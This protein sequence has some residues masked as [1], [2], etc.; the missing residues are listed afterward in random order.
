MF[1]IVLLAGSI[2]FYFWL[3]SFQ[4]SQV[5]FE[6]SGPSQLASGEPAAFTISYW[7]NTDQ[8]L[9]NAVLTVRYP[10]NVVSTGAVLER[11]DLGS[12]GVGSGGKQEINV[13]FFGADKS[14]VRLEAVLNY[15]PA[16]TS[17]TF[18]N[19]ARKDAGL[20]GSVLS[21][22]FKGPEA[23]LY[24]TTENYVVNY[25]NNTDKVFKDVF[26]E[27]SYPSG[28]NLTSSSRP[29]SVNNNVWNLG[30]LNPREEGEIQ[31]SGILKNSTERANF[32]VGIGIISGGKLFKFSQSTGQVNLTA[33]PLKLDIFLEEGS[34]VVGPG[35][36]LKFKI[37]YENGAGIALSDAVLK[38]Q[39]SGLMYDLA[40]LRSDG[41]FTS[42]NNTITWNAGNNPV[43]GSIPAG[44]AG[45]V[46]FQINVRPAYPIRSFRDKN[47]ALK[48]GASL[49]TP[50]VPSS[51]SAKTLL[52]KS[53]I[54]LKVAT[55]AVLKTSGYYFDALLKNS[56]PL[57]PRVGQTTTYTIH[58]Q[59]TNFSNDL[60]EVIV[61]SSL[62]AGV[63][64]LSKTAG[65]GAAGLEYNDRTN[66]LVWN[67][68]KTASAVGVLSKSFETAFQ[69]AFAPAAN[70]IGA[71][72]AIFE[73]SILT[74]KDLFTG[75]EV[76]STAKALKSDL[77]DDPGVG[78]T[79]GRVGQ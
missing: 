54:S 74:G 62:P 16:N 15:K 13:A 19:E 45:D 44:A 6:I 70:Q 4:K 65:P 50:T 37:R 72:A 28:F 67:V 55:K 52:V 48:A 71:F 41:F 12:I 69:V 20:S 33:L 17:S 63:S 18:N 46:S 25:K 57:P 51:L 30:D 64:W 66:E 40:T 3:T 35:E 34:E 26:I 60:D 24:G 7:N 9:Q 79:K 8:I 14:I 10:Q 49:E 61:K 47:F 38:V 22:D 1:G 58:W 2:L 5:D 68:G 56:G 36:L 29:P 43:L 42:S 23:A 77:P 31:L 59:I 32:D 75:R 53:D 27:V 21:V 76:S 39:L 78:L 73:E 11:I